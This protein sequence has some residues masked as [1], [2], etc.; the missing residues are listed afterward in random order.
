MGI[1]VILDPNDLVLERY[2]STGAVFH[3]PICPELPDLRIV[4]AA[5][6]RSFG[7]L[8]VTIENA[9]DV[10]LESTNIEMFM[11]I[12]SG[13]PLRPAAWQDVQL[14]PW[15]TTDI[16][17][18]GAMITPEIRET[19]L[20]GYSLTIDPRDQ[21]AEQDEDN[22]IHQVPG[23]KLVRVD[24]LSFTPP[25]VMENRRHRATAHFVV[26]IIGG[27]GSQRVLHVS[28]PELSYTP[29]Y[30]D[31]VPVWVVTTPEQQNY[32]TDFIEVA[33]DENVQ[34][35]ATANMKFGGQNI[36]LGR[37]AALFNIGRDAAFFR[38]QTGYQPCIGG[39]EGDGYYRYRYYPSTNF[40]TLGLSHQPYWAISVEM[41]SLE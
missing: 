14:D 10:P 31:N 29:D 17:W 21:I 41:C 18:T 4:D 6:N 22:N 20:A 2:E 8:N 33:G 23:Q 25:Y 7:Q 32:S 35:V 40:G 37:I 1:C 30:F 39:E 36:S 11:Q 5:F 24:W 28:S 27:G 13:S 38:P 16:V 12:P 26:D 9:S 19:M 3:Q 15:G 34:L